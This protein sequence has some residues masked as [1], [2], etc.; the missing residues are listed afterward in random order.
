MQE[1]PTIDSAD[2]VEKLRMRLKPE[3]FEKYGEPLIP[4]YVRCHQT[5]ASFP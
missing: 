5:V 3:D 1:Y 4:E 2:S